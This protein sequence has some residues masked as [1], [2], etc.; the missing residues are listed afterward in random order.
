M[1]VVGILGVVVS[2]GGR[3]VLCPTLGPFLRATEN[4]L[5]AIMMTEAH[6]KNDVAP[7]NIAMVVIKFTSDFFG[8]VCDFGADLGLW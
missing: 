5:S 3:I 4:Y 7:S 2:L 6:F 8:T 1:A